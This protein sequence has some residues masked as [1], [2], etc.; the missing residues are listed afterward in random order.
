MAFL[1]HSRRTA[2]DLV[3]EFL[4]GKKCRLRGKN[5]FEEKG[6]AAKHRIQVLPGGAVTGGHA[7]LGAATGSSP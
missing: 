1:S 4:S 2:S 3:V 7:K 5:C 6:G